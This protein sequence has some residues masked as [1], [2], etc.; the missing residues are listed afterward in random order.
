[1]S[2]MG[3]RIRSCRKSLGMTQEEL[4]TKIGVQKSAI[5][6]YENGRVDNIKRSQI[7]AMATVFGVS[8]VWLMGIEE[9][10][11]EESTLTEKE[12]ILLNLIRQMSDSQIDNLISFLE[13]K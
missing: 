4:G 10:K 8:P 9:T 5:A 6:K 11:K 12:Q 13:S 3:D 2:L 7:Q 1:M